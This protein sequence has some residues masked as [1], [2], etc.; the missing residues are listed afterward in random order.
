MN[1]DHGVVH[2]MSFDRLGER[3]RRYRLADPQA[4]EAM[5]V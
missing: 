4:E 1:W 2:P 3:Y 5:P